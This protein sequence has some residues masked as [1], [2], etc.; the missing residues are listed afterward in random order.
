MKTA[1]GISKKEYE[2]ITANSDNLVPFIDA[3]IAAVEAWKD[4]EVYFPFRPKRVVDC[5]GH[6]LKMSPE[7]ELR[8]LL[9]LLYQVNRV[10]Q[11]RM[12]HSVIG[13]RGFR[14]NGQGIVVLEASEMGWGRG[15]CTNDDVGRELWEEHFQMTD[16][17]VS[18]VKKPSGGT[19][20]QHVHELLEE[21]LTLMNSLPE[22]EFPTLSVGWKKDVPLTET[23]K[24][25]GAYYADRIDEV[26]KNARE[27]TIWNA[28]FGPQ[29]W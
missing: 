2:E 26:L 10:D 25:E 19:L 20:S 27:Q 17:I 5:V 11:M 14:T 13:G 16:D 24:I 15:Y 9:R 18:M 6:I 29:D 21:Q 23:E 22:P 8:T 12:G 28:Y 1:I 7:I 4:N 3:T